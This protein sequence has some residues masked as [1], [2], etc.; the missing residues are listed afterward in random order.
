MGTP[1]DIAIVHLDGTV[2]A[3]SVNYDGYLSGMGPLL[4]HHYD[5]RQKIIDM[6]ALGNYSSLGEDSQNSIAYIR[7]RGEGS[8]EL[9]RTF[10]S[11]HDYDE[12]LRYDATYQYIFK[13]DD[14]WYYASSDEG[15]LPLVVALAF[16]AKYEDFR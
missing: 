10:L 1:C 7:D 16:L 3:I 4:L 13:N 15:E 9:S 5:D 12:S 14:T 8:G 2:E 6:L 11:T